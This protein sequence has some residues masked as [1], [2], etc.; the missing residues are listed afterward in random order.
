MDE[1]RG[2]HIKFIIK[3]KFKLRRQAQ[4]KFGFNEEIKDK[5]RKVIVSSVTRDSIVKQGFKWIWNITN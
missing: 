1:F 4:Q 2:H 5:K 3:T